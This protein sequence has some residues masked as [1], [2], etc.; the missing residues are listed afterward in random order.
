V[1]GLPLLTGNPTLWWCPCDP[2]GWL[3]NDTHLSEW[4]PD[5]SA[6]IFF[7]L[8]NELANV[9]DDNPVDSRSHCLVCSPWCCTVI[10]TL[11][12]FSQC[13][14]YS[15]LATAAAAALESAEDFCAARTEIEP[16]H[17]GQ[18][19]LSPSFM[20]CATN[21][22]RVIHLPSCGRGEIHHRSAHTSARHTQS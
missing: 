1:F 5:L 7:L 15:T 3:T 8:E 4:A 13:L 22:E 19:L 14:V 2:L 9:Y 17:A 18:C 10:A 16:W 6:L 21:T 12:L 20:F 11:F